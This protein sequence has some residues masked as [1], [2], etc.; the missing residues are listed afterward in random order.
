M[1]KLHNETGEQHRTTGR[2]AELSKLKSVNI[3]SHLVG[4]ILFFLLPLY[5]YHSV[6][7]RQPNATVADLVV[8]ATFFFGVAICFLLSAS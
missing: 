4:S 7:L 3:H 6:Y 8:F 1:F 2:L 5:A